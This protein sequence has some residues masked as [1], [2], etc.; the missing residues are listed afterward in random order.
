MYRVFLVCISDIRSSYLIAIVYILMDV[1]APVI[2]FTLI[3]SKAS[4]SRPVNF[5]VKVGVRSRYLPPC[6]VSMVV[7][8]STKFKKIL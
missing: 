8:Y 7:N 6:T 4:Y 5:E 2:I 3:I 1:V